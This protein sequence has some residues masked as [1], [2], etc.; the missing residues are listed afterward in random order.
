MNDVLHWI[1]A[2]GPAAPFAFVG[3]YAAATVLFV[4][5]SALT[6]AGGALFG[7]LAGTLYSLAG[8]TLGATAAFLVSRHLARDAVTRRLHGKAAAI[9]RGV[10]EEGWR[11][12]AFVRLMP[13]LPFN[14]LNYALGLTR[15]PL[16]H[17]VAASFA[18]MLPG[19]AAYAYLGYAGREALAG[20]DDLIKNGLIAAALLAAAVYLPR[21][22]RRLHG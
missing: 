12:V 1:Q 4:P 22:A 5:G 3:A 20:P 17:Y 19:A 11:F 14:A 9:A 7:P 18:A 15:I 2:A 10:D 21:L 6:L 13:L 8:A 16:W